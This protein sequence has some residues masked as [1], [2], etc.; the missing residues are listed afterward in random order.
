VYSDIKLTIVRKHG[1]ELQTF[2]QSGRLGY[3]GFDEGRYNVPYL[4][5]T[6]LAAESVPQLVVHMMIIGASAAPSRLE[7]F[8][9]RGR[10]VKKILD[11]DSECPF[12][13][14]D[15]NRDG[16]YEICSYHPVGY[17]LCHAEQPRWEDIY[18]YKN[19]SYQL[20][21]G[22]FPKEYNDLASEI[23][24]ALKRHPNDWELLKYSGI[25]NKIQHRNRAALYDLKRAEEEAVKYRAEETDPE[26]I[27]MLD[28]GLGDI[29]KNMRRI[30][31]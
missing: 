20:A 11:I 16:R 6:D 17:E 5:C 12:I 7:V 8:S 10:Q 23:G 13:V 19:G 1:R 25:V 24:D 27:K 29:R 30:S 28:Q 14:R 15:F 22:D 3:P 9:W 18:A 21:N 4:A 2:W 26:I 31:K